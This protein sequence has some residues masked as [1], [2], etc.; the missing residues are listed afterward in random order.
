M[1]LRVAILWFLCLS[2]ILM[3]KT[4]SFAIF[5]SCKREK[6]SGAFSSPTTERSTVLSKIGP[7]RERGARAPLA[8]T[9]RRIFVRKSKCA[10][11]DN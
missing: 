4:D 9:L 1:G 8:I 5:F 7:A 11:V 3:E 2:I 10:R 6:R